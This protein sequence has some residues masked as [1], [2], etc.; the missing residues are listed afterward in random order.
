MAAGHSMMKATRQAPERMPH[1]TVIGLAVTLMAWALFGTNPLES[2]WTL[3]VVLICFRWFLWKEH[4]AIL[5]YLLIL[6]FIEGHTSVLHA[7]QAGLL[8]DDL[9]PE[10]GR[11]TF[12]L[13]SFGFLSVMM[14]CQ[15]ALQ[16]RRNQSSFS[17]AALRE[18]AL[19]INQ[20]RLILAIF[21]AHALASAL[22]RFIPYGSSLQQFETYIYA[23]PD[24]LTL[25]FSIHF[26][27]TRQR[28]LLVFGLFL[29]LFLTSFYS[30]FSTWRMPIVIALIG[31]ITSL[32]QLRLR[33]ILR[34]TPAAIPV[35]LL[36]LSWQAVKE[37]YRSF[38]SGGSNDQSI[39][40]T[41]SAAISKFSELATESVLSNSALEDEVINSTYERAGYL[42][43]FSAAVKKVPDEIPYQQGQLT[44]ESLEF[45]LIPRILN[46]NKG[47]KND[48]EKVERF[49]DYYFGGARNVSSFSLGHYCEAYIDWGPTGMMLHLLL[50]GF[51]GGI[52]YLLILRRT[53]H[54][55]P[56]LA[57]G[58]AYAILLPWGT[59]QSDLV[60]ITG[61]LFWGAVCQLILFTPFYT[62]FNR[63][64]QEQS[65]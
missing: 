28:P 60:T 49:T 53:E 1:A 59:F 5:F 8:L 50:Y 25:A 65:T 39:R 32:K 7:N 58:L 29:Y 36:V 23:I 12:W 43:Y 47:V 17:I 3:A 52:I 64:I 33:E 37:D 11:T 38:L 30:Y 27:L 44:G 4:P 15:L 51:L 62:A 54:L 63:Y 41:Q 48:R 35:L 21:I 46:P 24:A 26:F 18:A 13:A 40:V 19:K 2:I 55:N 10:T 22:A 9:F 34:L 42:E 6:P 57:C 61:K 14:G 31:Y 16:R 56:L 20:T 45:A